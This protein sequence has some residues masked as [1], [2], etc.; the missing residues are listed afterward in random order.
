LIQKPPNGGVLFIATLQLMD[1]LC[2]AQELFS[3]NN[4]SATITQ[5]VNMPETEIEKSW[6]GRMIDRFQP[7]FTELS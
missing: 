3:N 5:L 1:V 7:T 2:T 4:T 6:R